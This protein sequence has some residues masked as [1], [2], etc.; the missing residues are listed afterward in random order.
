M[1]KDLNEYKLFKDSLVIKLPKECECKLAK[2][3]E[4]GLVAYDN[5]TN[6]IITVQTVSIKERISDEKMLQDVIGVLKKELTDF[7][8]KGVYKKVTEGG[9]I[10][11]VIMTYK[12]EKGRMFAMNG[13]LF[14]D[15]SL[16]I[17]SMSTPGYYTHKMYPVFVDILKSVDYIN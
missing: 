16:V 1:K 4:Y 6:S 7:D 2:D 5:S 11:S 15:M 10:H 12:N 8:L 13:Y 14:N 17:V 9:M 3:G